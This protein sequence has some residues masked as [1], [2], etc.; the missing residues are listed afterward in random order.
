MLSVTI[1]GVLV[2]ELYFCSF[3]EQKRW[4]SNT[5]V[6]TMPVLYGNFLG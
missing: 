4:H 5:A 3:S 2:D 1:L 6:L